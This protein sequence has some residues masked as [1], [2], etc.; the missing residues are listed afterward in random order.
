MNR[1]KLPEYTHAVVCRRLRGGG[2]WRSSWHGDICT[3]MQSIHIWSI[4][5]DS[6][7]T[8]SGSGRIAADFAERVSGPDGERGASGEPFLEAYGYT[9]KD[10]RTV[11][12][13]AAGI[14][15]TV[16]AAGILAACLLPVRQERR[17]AKKR[18]RE[19]TGYL[20]RV[21]TD[22]PERFWRC[23]KM[24]LRICR[25]RSTKRSPIC[26]RPGTRP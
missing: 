17:A 4:L 3:R 11:P 26:M 10:F 20:E 12:G 5:P 8:G 25:M 23:G 13:T 6:S 1:K 14:V 2:F 15:C 16:C 22:A 24:S 7:G 19:L 18:I 9:P 21:N